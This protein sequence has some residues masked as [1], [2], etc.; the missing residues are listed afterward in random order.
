[1]EVEAKFRVP[2]REAYR[3]LLRLRRIGEYDII[4]VA[5]VRVADRYFDTADGRLLAGGYSCRLRTQGDT[6]V[7]TLKGLG[8][9]AGAVHRRDEQEVALPAALL[10]PA[11]WP[12]SPARELAL[13]LTRGA[14]LGPLFDLHQTRTKANLMQGAR[15]VAEWSLDEVRAVVGQ[16]PAFYYELEAELGP[17][18]TEADLHALTQALQAEC[19]LVPERNSKFMRGL[20]MLRVRGA[21]V[22]GDLTAEERAALQA[23]AQGADT[24]LA[25]RAATILAW[26]DDLPTREIVART[27]LS[28]GRVRF[29]LRAFRAERMGIFADAVRDETTPDELPEV[30]GAL[31]GEDARPVSQPLAEL[32]E[33]EEV[34]AAVSARGERIAAAEARAEAKVA[35]AENKAKPG[36]SKEK[37][38]GL[39]SV[40]EFLRERGVDVQRARFAA[41][42]AE[43]LFDGLRKVHGLPKKRASLA[44]NAALLASV[45]ATL[46][47]E[48][49]ARAGRDL[50]LAQPLRDVSTAERL[51]LACIVALQ[52]EKMKPNKEPALEALEPKER[53]EAIALAALLRMATSITFGG[54][55][56]ANVDCADGCCD[57]LLAGPTAEA[58]AALASRQARYWRELFKCEVNFATEA[59]LPVTLP[60]VEIKPKA[61][62]STVKAA[63]DQAAAQPETSA[64]PELPPLRSDD[65]MSEAGRK[66]MWTHFMKMLA[67]EAGTREGADIE[68]LHDMRVSTRRLRAA[69]M[70]FAPFYEAQAIGQFNKDMRKAGRTLGAVRDLDV[71]IEKAQAYEASPPAEERLTI[72]PLL[73]HWAAQR[74]V[75]RRE[76]SAFVDGNAY[77]RFVEGFGAFLLTPG[78]GAKAIPEG[79]P[80][81]HQVRHVIPRLVM[82]RYEQVR[83]YEPIIATAPL[84]TYHMLRID[85][86]RLRY[87]LEF[88][89]K[90]LGP[91][92]PGVIKQ[93]TAMQEL[94]GAMQDAHVAEGVIAEFLA[95]EAGRKKKPATHLG[96]EAYLETQRQIQQDLLGQFEPLWAVLTGL[97]FRRDLGSALSTP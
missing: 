94:L 72:Q 54:A 83:A 47:P 13:S 45:G 41:D 81:A 14:A 12:E 62:A 39:P 34:A 68:F 15:R 90:L 30:P 23:H 38:Q 93:V 49:P 56:I 26:A 96:V 44:R 21:A 59:P 51:A 32:G 11:E 40:A 7:A 29:W 79:E 10:D 75:A 3:E 52:R 73:D 57:V 76:M 78:M 77:K 20:E 1:M 70:I 74:E 24:E 43:K 97:E 27:G 31:A 60:D 69:F 18:G 67:N 80:V 88:F 46:D 50:I 33:P 63:P 85:C 4:P 89:Q 16:R 66:V 48:G 37:K 35:V 2:N 86:K 65:P 25:R 6:V 91:N 71:L 8:E 87:A 53:K 36:D 84:T 9:S 58:D 42:N 92:A 17:D 61:A 82:E 28:S 19:G 55:K 95:Q 5:R 64:A 22:E